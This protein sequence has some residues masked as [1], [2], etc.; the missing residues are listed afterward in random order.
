MCRCIAMG[1]CLIYTDTVVYG[2]VIMMGPNRQKAKNE[3]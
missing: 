3:I 1:R 2:T